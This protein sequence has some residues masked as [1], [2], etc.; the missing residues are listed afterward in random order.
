MIYALAITVFMVGLY[1]VCCKKNIIKIIQ[2]VII[3]EYALNFFIILLG[4][5]KGGIAPIINK[6]TDM[7]TFA[8]QSVDTLPQ[9]IVFISILIGLGLLALM[10]ALAIRLYE[11]YGTFDITEMKKLKG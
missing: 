3:M 8:A 4:Y 7:H 9:A 6:I 5:R 10:V 1:A 2:G 11:R